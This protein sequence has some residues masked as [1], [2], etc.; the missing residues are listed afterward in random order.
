MLDKTLPY[1]HIVMVLPAG[2][3][4]CTQPP[5][6]PDGYRLHLYRPGEESLWAELEASV[7]EFPGRGAALS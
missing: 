1:Y 7:G 2:R 5:D 3:N 6:V 4:P